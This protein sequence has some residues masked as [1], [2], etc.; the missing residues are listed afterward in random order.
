MYGLNAA[1]ALNKTYHRAPAALRGSAIVNQA[2]G[3]TEPHDL[4][5]LVAA[6]GKVTAALNVHEQ[7]L[8]EWAPNFDAFFA[9]F[10]AQSSSL[11]AAIAHLPGS[12]AQRRSGVHG[13][14]RL[15]P[16][17][18]RVRA[19]APPGRT[20]RQG[21]R[22]PRRCRGSNRCRRRWRRTS[23]AGSPGG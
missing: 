21:R 16:A 2:L 17:D 11:S 4:S 8:G 9:A 23:S 19:S 13:A 18:A 20:N 7:A 1:Q 3:G 6:I 14:R 22:S 12:A 15:V 10:A 5:E